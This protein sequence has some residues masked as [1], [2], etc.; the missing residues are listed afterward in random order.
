MS[1]ETFISRRLAF[2]K[3]KT[4]SRLIIR[5]AVAAVALSVAVMIAATAMIAGFQR[6][7]S[8]KIFGFWGHVH[9]SDTNSSLS[10]EPTPVMPGQDFLK[11]LDT[12]GPISFEKESPTGG[13]W[14]KARTRG[15]IAHVQAFAVK[16]GIIKSKTEIEGI[17]LKGVG[18]DFDWARLRPYL[19]EGREINL[20][21]TAAS[22]DILV[23][24]QTADRLSV[25]VGDKFVVYFVKEGQQLKRLFQVCGIYKTGLEE[26][27]RKFALCDLR[28][29]QRLLGWQRGEVAG[30]EVFLDDIR[31][32]EPM[33]E[34]IHEEVLPEEL[35]ATSIRD[36]FPAIFEWL[37]LQDYNKVVI[38]A[39]MLAVAI[40]N[41]V[42]A[43]LILILERTN[44]IGTL[45]A[46]GA[47]NGQVRRIFL[48]H[49]AWITGAGLLWGNLLGLLFCFLEWRFRFIRLPEADYFLSYAPVAVDWPT[50][51]WLNAGTLA[52]TLLVLLL[53]A[54]LVHRVTPVKA[55]RFK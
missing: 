38:L 12:L 1:L 7:I 29:V 25:G 55:I 51:L 33:A 37:G 39:L 54:L 34:F 42:T 8:N 36:K 19:L 41:M 16:P 20:A 46:L 10:F 50:V 44:M 24:R 3:E 32:M 49:A 21:D 6:E 5:I 9:I 53:P 2:S 27:D 47:A 23:S 43:L 18:P 30:Y 35:L 14:Q 13:G 17:L 52:V 15:G 28:Q 11:M 22:R 4:F 45:K 40:V 48:I 26:F 31:D